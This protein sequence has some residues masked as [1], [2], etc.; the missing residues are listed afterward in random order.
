MQ[1]IVYAM[2]AKLVTFVHSSVF[3]Y[4]YKTWIAFFCCVFFFICKHALVH[5]LGQSCS[6][7]GSCNNHVGYYSCSCNTGYQGTNCETQINYCSGGHFTLHYS[8]THRNAY[9][10]Q[11]PSWIVAVFLLKKNSSR[12]FLL[13]FQVKLAVVVV[14]VTITWVTIP[15][16]VTLATRVPTVKLKS[17]TVPVRNLKHLGLQTSVMGFGL[18]LP[19]LN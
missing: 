11:F 7:R 13:F 8:Y 3:I 18:M 9:I 15:A 4:N 14:R 19:E 16:R 2:F 1:R 17:T 6:G 10:W 5:V 12:R